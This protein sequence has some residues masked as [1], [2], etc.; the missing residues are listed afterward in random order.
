MYLLVYLWKKM[1]RLNE[2]TAK[3]AKMEDKISGLQELSV[4]QGKDI[5]K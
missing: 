5:R 4:F 3:C 2:L 1:E